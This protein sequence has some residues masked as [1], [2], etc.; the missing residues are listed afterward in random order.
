MR[1]RLTA[2]LLVLGCLFATGA[3]ATSC[4]LFQ[5]TETH[6]SD[7]VLDAIY[8]GMKKAQDHPS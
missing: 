6:A 1:Q 7:D 8:A 4:S 5:R 2:A 3:L